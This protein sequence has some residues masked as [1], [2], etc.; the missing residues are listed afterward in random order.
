ME[1]ME[2]K[3][4][5]AALAGSVNTL[6]E[7]LQQDRLILERATMSYPSETPLHVAALLGHEDFARE[8]LRQKPGIAGELD[9]RK[10][11]A[12]HIASQKGYVGI[13]KALLE[14][15]P[16]MCSAK[17]VDGRNPLHLAAMKGR[18]DV[19]EE[20]VG[21]RPLAAS[22]PLIWGET[23]LHLCVK[24]IQLEALKFLLENME[25]SEFFNAKDDYGMT[26]LHLAVADKQIEVWITHITYKSRVLNAHSRN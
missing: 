19:L 9:S 3:L 22:A 17:D 15:N 13:V 2:S 16:D 7:L 23:I 14:V 10:S 18:V 24:H 21:T 6:L 12:L 26:I 8:I 20:L 1:N 4:C 25:D 5:E 11:S